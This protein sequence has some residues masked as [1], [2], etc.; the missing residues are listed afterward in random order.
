MYSKSLKKALEAL[1]S[2]LHVADRGDLNAKHA[3]MLPVANTPG[4]CSR[5]RQTLIVI[6]TKQLMFH[7]II[8]STPSFAGC[9][10]VLRSP[11]V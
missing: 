10:S 9:S 4:T 2:V 6:L 7:V 11:A 3:A 5:C 8:R 1:V